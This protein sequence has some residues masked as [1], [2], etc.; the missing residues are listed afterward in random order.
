MTRTTIAS[1]AALDWSAHADPD[2]WPIAEHLYL[3]EAICVLGAAL[4]EPH[5][6]QANRRKSL[7]VGRRS[8]RSTAR[9]RLNEQRH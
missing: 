7:C 2:R 1:L 9:S 3:A 5:P 4:C 8:P 6:K